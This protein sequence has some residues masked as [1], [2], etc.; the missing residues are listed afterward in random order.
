MIDRRN[1]LMRR[2]RRSCR[3]CCTHPRL[4]QLDCI[5]LRFI[6]TIHGYC[7]TNLHS[8]FIASDVVISEHL[9]RK[10][11]LPPDGAP[12]GKACQ[13]FARSHAHG[14]CWLILDHNS[15]KP[16]QFLNELWERREAEEQEL[17]IGIFDF[18]KGF[19]GSSSPL[20]ARD[21][22]IPPSPW[23]STTTSTPRLRSAYAREK[24]TMPPPT[25]STS[26]V[27]FIFHLLSVLDKAK[28]DAEFFHASVF[29]LYLPDVPIEAMHFGLTTARAR[30]SISQAQC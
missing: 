5:H 13:F 18:G 24:P 17:R 9:Y 16:L 2:E 3:D 6:G 22:C 14:A 27:S 8:W 28:S 1:G 15:R 12:R 4:H 26:V 25:M 19:E 29:R 10:A 11:C 23:S 21:A 30:D 7:R 20:A